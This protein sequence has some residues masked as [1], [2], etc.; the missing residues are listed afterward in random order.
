MQDPHDSATDIAELLQHLVQLEVPQ[1][2][3]DGEPAA[4]LLRYSVRILN[5]RMAGGLV[6][7]SQSA[8][9]ARRRLV[10][11]GRPSDA[12]ALSEAIGRL[13]AG[14]GMRNLP[15]A[16][17]MLCAL[18]HSTPHVAMSSCAGA[19][20]LAREAPPAPPMPPLQHA[21]VAAPEPDVTPREAGAAPLSRGA[22]GAAS[23]GAVP[24]GTDEASERLLV[25]DVLFVLQNIDGATIKWD[26][27]RDAFAPPAGMRLPRASRQ[28][29]SRL[30]ELGWLFRQI[31]GYIKAQ[32]APGGGGGLVAQAF[33]HALQAELGEWYQLL[34]V[35]DAQRQSELSLVQLLVWSHEPTQRMLVM[36]QVGVRVTVR[37]RG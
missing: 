34:A 15:A 5:S 24:G 21:H 8:E 32:A 4:R 3:E 20:L 11:A 23:S 25:R 33:C 35:L 6:P 27:A 18:M 26:A 17:Q 9:I 10:Q 16:L 7:E 36:T 30:C 14:H 37:V 1:L 31:D 13:G 12:L 29:V 22:K 28:L 2:P 19:A